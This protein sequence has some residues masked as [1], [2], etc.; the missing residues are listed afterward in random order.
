[1][2]ITFH[3]IRWLQGIALKRWLWIERTWID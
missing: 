3:H 2:Y 1:M